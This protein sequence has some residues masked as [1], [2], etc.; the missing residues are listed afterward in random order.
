MATVYRVTKVLDVSQLVDSVDAIEAFA[1]E[2]GPGRYVVDEHTSEP[3]P[4][5]TPVARA[6]GVVVHQPDGRVAMKP[7]FYGDHVAV[8]DY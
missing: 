3:L 8:E 2:H 1:R 6:W 5:S 7:F 4:R